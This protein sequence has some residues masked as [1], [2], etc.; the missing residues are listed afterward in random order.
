MTE[1]AAL[2][3][4]NIGQQTLLLYHPLSGLVGGLAKAKQFLNLTRNNNGENL[5]DQR[6]GERH[7]ACSVVVICAGRS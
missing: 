6:Q 4:V 7:V 1:Q 2:T 5:R 3:R